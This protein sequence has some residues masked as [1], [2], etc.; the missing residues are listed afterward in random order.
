MA[1]FTL[2]P[3]P[4]SPFLGSDDEELDI[5]DIT[6]PLLQQWGIYDL[7][8]NPVVSTVGPG[9]MPGNI[10]SFLELKYSN[11]A[12]VS[13]FPVEKGQFATYNKTGTPYSPK[14][15]VAVAGQ[16]RMQTLMELVENELDTI[17]LYNLIT[18][19][20]TY[21]SVTLEKYEYTRSAKG[22][23][24][25]LHVMLTFVQV[26]E[27]VPNQY[28]QTAIISPKK[29]AAKDK[30]GHGKEQVQVLSDKKLKYNARLIAHGVPAGSPGSYDTKTGEMILR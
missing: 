17:N 27:V 16:G 5:V 20:R 25:L 1:N 13:N 23:K 15:A 11:N 2:P 14:V 6:P 21:T 29:P 10:D 19:E 4:S 26:V 24:N 8:G 22:G 28:S 7:A 18:P 9:G 30:E 3:N 12:K